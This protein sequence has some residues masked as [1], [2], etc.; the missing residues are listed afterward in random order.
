M[1]AKYPTAVIEVGCLLRYPDWLRAE[2]VYTFTG[3]KSFPERVS[4][5]ALVA[6]YPTAVKEV[7]YLHILVILVDAGPSAF[8]DDPTVGNSNEPIGQHA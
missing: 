5:F 7:G 3:R 1:C 2:R 4:R 8:T 6:I